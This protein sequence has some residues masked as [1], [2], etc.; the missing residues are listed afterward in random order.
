MNITQITETYIKEH[1]SI[2]NCLKNNLINYSKL[3]RLII[4][5]MHLEKKTTKDALLIAAR[6]YQTKLKKQQS[7]EKEI[8]A[9]LKKSE[10]EIK[11]K[12]V[13]FIVEKSLYLDNLLDLEKRIKKKADLFYT[14]EGTSA[15]TL[16]TTEK[17]YD[18]CIEF[19]KHKIVNESRELVMIIIKSSKDIEET[20]G[21]MA[22]LLSLF[23][24]NQVNVYEVMSCWTDTIFVITQNDLEKAMGFLKF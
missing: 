18:D 9:L 24:E 5:E 6:R 8:I 20:P 12:I 1:P 16:I 2:K 3:S 4:K 13:V 19:F 22:Y 23:A 10:I 21:V 11:T 17:Y 7:N 15:F 14:I